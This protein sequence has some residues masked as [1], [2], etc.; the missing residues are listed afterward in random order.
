MDIGA[1]GLEHPA[2]QV[3]SAIINQGNFFWGFVDTE[4]VSAAEEAG[5]LDD[6]I[7][8]GRRKEEITLCT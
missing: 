4:K 6:W 2:S 8:P 3:F 7:S 5:F 1:Q